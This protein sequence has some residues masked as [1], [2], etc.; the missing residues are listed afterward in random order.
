MQMLLMMLLGTALC[1]AGMTGLSLAMPRHYSQLNAAKLSDSDN[2]L[3]RLVSIVVLIFSL[4][5][6]ISVWGIVVGIV[7][8]LGLLS[9]AAVIL[10]SLLAYWPRFAAAKALILAFIGLSSCIILWLS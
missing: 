1:Y 5:P 8:W 6:V 9:V 4:W 3:L 10:V 7:V 2:H